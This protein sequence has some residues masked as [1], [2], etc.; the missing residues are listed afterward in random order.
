MEQEERGEITS[1]E[2]SSYSPK[3]GRHNGG[4]TSAVGESG[5]K[6]IKRPT[7]EASLDADFDNKDTKKML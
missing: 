4:F 3:G 6:T 7:L 2:S 1:S 5:K